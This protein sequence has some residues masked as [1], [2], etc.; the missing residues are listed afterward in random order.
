MAMALASGSGT[1]RCISR[2][3]ELQTL[4]VLTL[5]EADD[6]KAFKVVVRPGAA[7]LPLDRALAGVG[8]AASDG[9]A[10]LQIDAVKALAGD[11]ARDPAWMAAFE[12]M[13]AYAVR[14][15]WVSDDGQAIRA[16]FEVQAT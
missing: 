5:R 9:D 7:E 12:D 15:G 3:T 6:F 11:R 1:A 10:F 16:H 8:S 4:L 2:L 13:L 14:A